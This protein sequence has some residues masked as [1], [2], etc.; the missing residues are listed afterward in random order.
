[1]RSESKIAAQ[2]KLDRK[3]LLGF[4]NLVAVTTPESDIRESADLT[5]VKRGVENVA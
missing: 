3:K 5:F 1:M 2:P 4:R